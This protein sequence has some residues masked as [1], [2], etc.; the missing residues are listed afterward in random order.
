M[1]VR[2]QQGVLHSFSIKN[3][4]YDKQWTFTFT[5]SFLRTLHFSISQYLLS[6]SDKL[7][8]QIKNSHRTCFPVMF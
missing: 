4:F 7:R 2:H 1:N 6:V 3:I 5:L 8:E